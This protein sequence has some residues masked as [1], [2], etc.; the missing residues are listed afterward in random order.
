MV[1]QL[2]APL[3]MAY[4]QTPG[5]FVALPTLITLLMMIGPAAPR[6]K[7]WFKR[8]GQFGRLSGWR[9]SVGSGGSALPRLRDNRCWVAQHLQPVARLLRH[10][11]QLQWT[12][13]RMFPS[14]PPS[15]IMPYRQ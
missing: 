10:P 8:L 1:M 11:A 14:R 12:L 3:P 4:L 15:M 9:R 7:G 6:P 5:F 13:P 2:A